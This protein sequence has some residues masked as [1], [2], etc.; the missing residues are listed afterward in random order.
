MDE[1]ITVIYIDSD[2]RCFAEPGEGRRAVLSAAFAGMPPSEIERYRF[3]PGG[4]AW[5]REDGETFYG[6]MISLIERPSELE[7]M[8]AA[9]ALLGV[10][11]D[12]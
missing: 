3:I 7:D 8:R 12:E 5:T 4:E 2:F 11:D 10:T 1:N 6:G 9:L